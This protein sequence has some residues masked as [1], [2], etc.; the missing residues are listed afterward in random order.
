MINPQLLKVVSSY[1]YLS[2]QRHNDTV[3]AAIKINAASETSRSLWGDKPIFVIQPKITNNKVPKYTYLVY[4][5]GPS[6]S[7]ES[8]V[9]SE[10]IIIWWSELSPDTDRVLSAINWE[11]Y[12]KEIKYPDV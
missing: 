9:G 6:L 11:K 5:Q 3:S 4:A 12:A 1:C 2:Y 7:E 8:T 10:L